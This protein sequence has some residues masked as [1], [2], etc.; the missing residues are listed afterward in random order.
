MGFHLLPYL[1]ILSS[2]T[3]WPWVEKDFV[4]T[5]RLLPMALAALIL[6]LATMAQPASGAYIQSIQA[7]LG[8]CGNMSS[9]LDGVFT[10]TIDTKCSFEH[11]QVS[12]ETI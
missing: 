5:A 10:F 4:L 11:L 1:D 2:P 8:S 6:V 12:Q 7:I 3:I 9:D